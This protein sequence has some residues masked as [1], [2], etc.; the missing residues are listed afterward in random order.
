MNRRKLDRRQ[1]IAP[2]SDGAEQSV[3]GGLLLDN[4]RLSDVAAVIGE[5][6]FY[7]DD[8][9]RIFAHIRKLLEMGRPADVVTVSESIEKSNEVEQAGGLAYLAD[10]A[11]NTPSAANIVAY[12]RIVRERA[13][14]R[15]LAACGIAIHGLAV[16]PGRSDVAAVLKESRDRVAAVLAEWRGYSSPTVRP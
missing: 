2:A 6:H 9:R 14:L 10:I 13:I 7:R 16:S 11:N 4:T 3:L 5:P 1:P 8:H 12:A 15:D